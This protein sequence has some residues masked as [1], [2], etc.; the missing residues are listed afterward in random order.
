ML[1]LFK[2]GLLSFLY[3]VTFTVVAQNISVLDS[4]S[5]PLPFEPESFDFI[6]KSYPLSDEDYIATLEVTINAESEANLVAIFDA[7]WQKANDLG[8]N[9]YR[10]E[11]IYRFQDKDRMIVELSVHQVS[12]AEFH[13]MLDYYRS[14]MVYVIGSL[15]PR[16]SPR[17]MKLNDQKLLLPARQYLASQNEVGEEVSISIG[18]FL[19]A[20]VWVKGR[21]NRPPSHYALEG[22]AAG[23]G[24]D[25]N[26]NIG[27][28]F[29]T[30][31]IYPIELN[32]GQFLVTLLTQKVVPQP[33]GVND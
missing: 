2:P 11:G 33:E 14:N 23:P 30:G 25:Y 22:F 16:N 17:K 8:A 1:K 7:V 32:L 29:N 10:F 26:L 15:N 5:K 19:G 31:R 12:D 6:P 21:E 3:L 18:G 20:K 28:S 24:V 4:V 13:N 9:A 27:V